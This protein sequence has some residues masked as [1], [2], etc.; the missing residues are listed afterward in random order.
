MVCREVDVITKPEPGQ[1]YVYVH[2]SDQGAKPIT[3]KDK[4]LQKER[5]F[6]TSHKIPP[7]LTYKLNKKATEDAVKDTKHKQQ[8]REANPAEGAAPAPAGAIKLDVNKLLEKYKSEI[9]ATTTAKPKSRRVKK[10]AAVTVPTPVLT[11]GASIKKVDDDDDFT[12]DGSASEKQRSR[13]QIK[14]G[15]NGQEYEYEYVYY[16]YDDEDDEKNGKEKTFNSHDGPAREKASARGEKAKNQTPD[17]NEVIPSSRGRGNSRGRQLDED[18]DERLPANTR[19]PPRGRNID[20]TPSSE[21][22]TKPS[23]GR[24]RTQGRQSDSSAE[25]NYSEETQV[26]IFLFLS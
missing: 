19:F 9:K 23:R 10:D 1:E 14:K 21:E 6:E 5:S 17:A 16:Y 2:S 3:R 18:S 12:L 24:S 4:P 22:V 11:T 8:K 13:I 26:S 25:D 15:P 7:S 20:T